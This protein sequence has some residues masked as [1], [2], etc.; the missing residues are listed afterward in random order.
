MSAD[1]SFVAQ[2]IIV[3]FNFPPIGFAMCDGQI[4]PISG[5]TALFSLLG[6]TY[7]GN[8]LTNFGL[9]NLQGRIPIGA[10]AGPGITNRDLGETG[11]VEQVT[12][13]ANEI[14][15]HTHLVKEVPLSLPA[16]DAVNTYN[17]VGSYHGAAA[18]DKLYSTTAGTNVTAKLQHNLNAA[19]GPTAPVNNLQPY[20]TINYAI[21]LRGV[22]PPRT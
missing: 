21:A 2:I 16:G 17:P 4:M 9:P 8:G 13:T 11:G 22:F 20:M 12:L 5:N 7:G 14:P 1:D 3:P 10:G 18:S 19:P 6:T 15:P